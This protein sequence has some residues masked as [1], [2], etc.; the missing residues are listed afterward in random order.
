MIADLPPPFDD[1]WFRFIVAFVIGSTLGSFSTMLA[2]R[3]PR[4]MSI[5]VP[6]SH[7]PTCKTPLRIMDL[8]PIL[9]WI[10]SR[11]HCRHCHAKIGARYI[12]IELGISVFC[13]IVGIAIGY[14]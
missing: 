11:G 1:A 10:S 5:L 2:Y 12:F 13:G 3:L 7:C 4:G 14:M 9:S 8:F 6:R